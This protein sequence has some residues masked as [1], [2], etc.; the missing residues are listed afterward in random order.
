[1]TVG[2]EDQGAA[3]GTFDA[4]VGGGSGQ[5][6]MRAGIESKAE[7]AGE[8]RHLGQG[9]REGG[10]E[11]G[12]LVIAEGGDDE[13]AERFCLNVGVDEGVG[14]KVGDQGA[15]GRL[16]HAPQLQVGAGREVDDAV[17]VGLG[18]IGDGKG[19]LGGEAA[20]RRTDA[21]HKPVTGLHRTQRAGAPALDLPGGHA[22]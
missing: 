4:D 15:V 14:A 22:A 12:G 7:F 21:D 19:L 9:S 2:A 3:R 13:I 11:S 1:M 18:G 5:H 6:R 16:G 17:A 8:L 10:G 20:Q